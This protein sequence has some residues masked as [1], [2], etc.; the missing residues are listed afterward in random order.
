[1]PGEV[2][3]TR[4]RAA[5][6]FGTPLKLSCCQLPDLIVLRPFDEDGFG[7]MCG[8]VDGPGEDDTCAERHAGPVGFDPHAGLKLVED[9]D[10]ADG[11]GEVDRFAGR[12]VERD[13]LGAGPFAGVVGGAGVGQNLDAGTRVEELPERIGTIEAFKDRGLGGSEG[14]E[15]KEDQWGESPDRSAAHSLKGGKSIP[16]Q[17]R[18][19]IGHGNLWAER[20]GWSSIGDWR[21]Q[22]AVTARPKSNVRTEGWNRSKS[23]F[24][25]HFGHGTRAN[26]A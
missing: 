3:K 25:Q 10:A 5:T 4:T 16:Q 6:S 13:L 9:R 14:R 26:V 21:P 11:A 8:W 19:A 15:N 24:Y 23:S 22:T 7:A 2:R 17:S 12:S 1:M 20:L 18:T